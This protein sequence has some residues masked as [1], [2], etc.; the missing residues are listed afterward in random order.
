MAE[1]Q[2]YS[3]YGFT[4]SLLTSDPAALSSDGVEGLFWAG[5]L[6]LTELTLFMQ[7]GLAVEREVVSRGC[8]TV[9]PTS[10]VSCSMYE[11]ERQFEKC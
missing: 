5:S 1:R 10:Y 11:A 2:N 6:W 3:F 8:N 9:T 4:E 7:G